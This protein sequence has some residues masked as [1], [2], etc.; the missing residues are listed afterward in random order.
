M[1]PF[2]GQQKLRQNFLDVQ[3]GTLCRQLDQLLDTGQMGVGP[4]APGKALRVHLQQRLDRGSGIMTIQVHFVE[5]VNC[6]ILNWGMSAPNE[7]QNLVER[8]SGGRNALQSQLHHDMDGLRNIGVRSRREQGAKTGLRAVDELNEVEALDVAVP[9]PE[10][11]GSLSLA[12]GLWI[13]TLILFLKGIRDVHGHR[14][15][16]HGLVFHASA[17]RLCLATLLSCC[18]LICQ[19]LFSLLGFLVLQLAK[20]HLNFIQ[21]L[22]C[23]HSL[24]PRTLQC[25][26][27]WVE[28]DQGT[29]ELHR[30]LSGHARTVLHPARR[31]LQNPA[32]SLPWESSGAAFRGEGR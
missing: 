5:G 7:A 22:L 32:P 20:P 10:E 26:T 9:H 13:I 8:P 16:G 29:S 25:R 30:R 28:L 24:V 6:R 4:G 17:L 18:S 31:N 12:L 23:L 11:C 27:I 2:D 3:K 19:S 21:E 15:V 14:F 1:G